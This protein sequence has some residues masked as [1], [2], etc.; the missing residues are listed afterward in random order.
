MIGPDPKL[1]QEG[2]SKG[3]PATQ[4]FPCIQIAFSKILLFVFLWFQIL[5]QTPFGRKFSRPKKSSTVLLNQAF[6]KNGSTKKSGPFH[7]PLNS[8][9][10]VPGEFPGQPL[11]SL[12]R[13]AWGRSGG[14]PVNP[15]ETSSMQKISFWKAFE[16]LVASKK[17]NKHF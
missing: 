10:F 6:S 17:K 1:P 16:F 12:D 5:T 3:R 7:A 4:K 14:C 9:N 15:E 8:K 11:A 13:W 2:R